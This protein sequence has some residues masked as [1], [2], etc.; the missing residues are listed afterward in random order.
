MLAAAGVMV[1]TY[2]LT[3]YIENPKLLLP[4]R[5][6]IAAILYFAVMK[7]AKAAILEECLNFIKKKR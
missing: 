6:V 1:A 7:V 3:S 2:L 5:I 4:L